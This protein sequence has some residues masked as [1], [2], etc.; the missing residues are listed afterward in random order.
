MA[1]EKRLRQQQQYRQY[2]EGKRTRTPQHLRSNQEQ[3]LPQR[4][5]AFRRQ[6]KRTGIEAIQNITLLSIILSTPIC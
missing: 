4:Q 5:Q 1:E 3:L 6:T 2:P